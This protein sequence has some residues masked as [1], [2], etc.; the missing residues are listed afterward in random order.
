MGTWI[1]EGRADQGLSFPTKAGNWVS[2][3]ECKEG[4]W[5][6]IIQEGKYPSSHVGWGAKS[7]L[8][9]E[10]YLRPNSYSFHLEQGIA[11]DDI[12]QE[13]TGFV[14]GMGES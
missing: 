3:D 4:S 1:A 8:L 12:G 13:Q 2:F 7:W 14:E 11:V 9:V 6:A 10:K 5:W